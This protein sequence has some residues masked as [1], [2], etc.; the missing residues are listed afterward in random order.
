MNP[1][2]FRNIKAHLINARTVCSAEPLPQGHDTNTH[3]YVY[4]CIHTLVLA[5]FCANVCGVG[6]VVVVAV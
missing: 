6:V 3:A 2:C 4:T 1:V 5:M